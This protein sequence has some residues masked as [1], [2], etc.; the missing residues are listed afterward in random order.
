[1]KATRREFLKTTALATAGTALAPMIALPG[2]QRLFGEA[3]AAAP[4]IDTSGP[5]G[6][7]AAVVDYLS[8]PTDGLQRRLDF[9]RN[10]D[11]I[12]DVLPAADMSSFLTFER[13]QVSLRVLERV[14]ED[15]FAPAE[16]HLYADW[17]ER[18]AH[19]SF[20]SD[21]ESKQA[22]GLLPDG[23]AVQ[24]NWPR[25]QVYAVHVSGGSARTLQIYAQG[26]LN[27]ATIRIVDDATNVVVE[28]WSSVDPDPGSTFRYARVTHATNLRPGRYRAIVVNPLGD[29]EQFTID[30]PAAAFD[31]SV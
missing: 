16:V 26:V 2:G 8:S 4:A 7:L 13:G 9:N 25:C 11:S 21:E 30:S 6:P 10:P 29:G 15:G 18:M 17:L 27:G 31:V 5:L 28:E 22:I 19:W 24:Y 20:E 23:A 12:R 3:V 1:M 14:S